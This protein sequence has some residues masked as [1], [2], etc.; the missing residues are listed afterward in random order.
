MWPW[1]RRWHGWAMHNIW[2]LT[3]FGPQTK[4]LHYS[5]EKAGLTVTNQPIPWGA[6]AVLVEALLRLPARTGRRK[7][8][9]SLKIPDREL[10]P[11]DALR[12]TDR[13]DCHRVLFRF[14]PPGRAVP[15]EILFRG[16]SLGR[17]QL[18]C[19]GREDFISSLQLLMPSLFVQLG[20]ETVAC[21]TFVSSQCRGLIASATLASP[22]CLVP[23]L[24]LDLQ[25]EFCSEE[26]GTSFLVPVR[27]SGSQLTTRSTLV[28]V[29]PT[30][31]PRKMG[32]WRATWL[33]GGAPLA[34]QRIRGISRRQFQRSLRISDTRFVVQGISKP[35]QLVRQMP[36]TMPEQRIGPCF[37]VSSAEPGMAGLVTLRV[38][39][40]VTGAVQPPVLMEQEVLITDGPTVVA[41]GT[42]DTAD[43]HQVSG[44][45]L[46]M[47]KRSLGLLPLSPAPSATFTSEGGYRPPSDYEWTAAAEEEMN[48]RL[49]R[50]LDTTNPGE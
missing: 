7:T 49:N 43:L 5:Y 50:L 28:T 6:E 44:F 10:V 41:P 38:A 20:S 9:F 2:P 26:G 12:R 47:G 25:I 22:T 45:E 13:D 27:L 11:A 3:Q 8:D 46:T 14:P 16:H 42:L 34:S 18:P 23:L 35:V 32:T 48:E 24:D 31:Y 29:A 17:V 33:L 30:R 39:A 37:L 40:Q 1:I 4:A 21:Q 19:V 15:V 36:A